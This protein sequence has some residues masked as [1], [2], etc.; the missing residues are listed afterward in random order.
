MQSPIQRIPG[1]KRGQGVTLTTHSPLV[2][3]SKMREAIHPLPL[4]AS[5]ATERQLCFYILLA[6]IPGVARIQDKVKEFE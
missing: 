6:E 4:S 1:V 2:P 3:R 5:M